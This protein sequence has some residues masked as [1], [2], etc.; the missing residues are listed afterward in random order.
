MTYPLTSFHFNVEWGAARGGFTEV[1]G[2]GLEYSAIE[3][4]EG[5]SPSQDSMKI[6]GLPTYRDLVLKRGMLAGDNAFFE[7]LNTARFGTV[8]RRDLLVSL[9]NEQHEPAVVWRF[10]NAW[11]RSI[12]G[13]TLR[14]SASE[15]AIETMTVA[16]EGMVVLNGN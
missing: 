10:R 16:H 15:V 11:A 13:P 7:W 4:R 8:E 12:D 2:L 9:L 5:N 14:S 6:P 1:T 3:Y